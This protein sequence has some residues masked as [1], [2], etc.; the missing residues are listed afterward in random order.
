MPEHFLLQRDVM[1]YAI[2][3][4]ERELTCPLKIFNS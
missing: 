1:Y 2:L 3:I 4:C